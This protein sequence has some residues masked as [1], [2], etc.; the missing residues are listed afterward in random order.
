M[1][2]RVVGERERICLQAIRGAQQ[3]RAEALEHAME[4]MAHDRLGNVQQNGV[5]KG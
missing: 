5:W 4:A 1:R 3:V 2:E